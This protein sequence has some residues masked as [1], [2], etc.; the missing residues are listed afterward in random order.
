MFN[1]PLF[2]QGKKSPSTSIK[3]PQ[4]ATHIYLVSQTFPNYAAALT[5]PPLPQ[6][7]HHIS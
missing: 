3:P 6:S 7:T 4:S 2:L 1:P 5:K